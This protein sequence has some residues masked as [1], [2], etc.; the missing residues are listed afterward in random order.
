MAQPLTWLMLF[1]KS[2]GNVL[3]EWVF[4][5]QAATHSPSIGR[6]TGEREITLSPVS[7]LRIDL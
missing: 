3:D 7:T 2:N 5:F 1:G 6:K 4:V